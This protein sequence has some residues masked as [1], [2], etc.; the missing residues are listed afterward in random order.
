MIRPTA[1]LCP[2]V[3]DVASRCLAT[4]TGSARTFARP[5]PFRI[6]VMISF[7]ARSVRRVVKS[8]VFVL[9][10]WPS[11]SSRPIAALSST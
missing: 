3:S 11:F 10:R 6:R 2:S 4:V 8:P 5:R 7:S 1:S 9:T